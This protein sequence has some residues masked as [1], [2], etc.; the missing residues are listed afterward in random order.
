MKEEMHT[1]EIVKPRPD[2]WWDD[3]VRVVKKCK[4][5]QQQNAE[6]K[7]ILEELGDSFDEQTYSEKAREQF[8][9]PDDREYGVNITAKQLRAISALLTKCGVKVN[10]R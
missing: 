10:E 5:L 1:G 3:Y 6:L 9:A 8:D 7:A 2:N 4:A